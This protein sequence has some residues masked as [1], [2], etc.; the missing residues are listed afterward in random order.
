M[1]LFRRHSERSR[2][3][4]ER[5]GEEPLYFTR[6]RNLFALDH[7]A[8]IPSGTARRRSRATPPFAFALLCLIGGSLAAPAQSRATA[9]AATQPTKPFMF[10]VVSIRQHN[11]A[12]N[13]FER[14]Y[15]PDGFQ[16]T[17][18]IQ[19]LISLAYTPN[20][21]FL[22]SLSKV[23]GAPSWAV[24]NLY[25]VQARVRQ[26]ELPAW[27]ETHDLYH[28]DLFRRG[29]QAALQDRAGLTVHTTT[30]EQPCLNLVVGKHGSRLEPAAPGVV[31]PIP[32]KSY[33]LGAG[34]Y[35]EDNG[36][37]QF[38]GVSMEELALLLT[39]LNKGHLVRDKTGLTGRYD[40]TLPVDNS[41]DDSGSTIPLDRMPVAS[42]GL[43]LK[44]GTA[45]F[46]NIYIDHI[47]RP[48][49]N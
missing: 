39:R 37:R 11:P 2:E 1:H 14:Q 41:P 49:A 43:A 9:S 8:V 34:F 36:R 31:K 26:D 33:K 47:E 45:P 35:I 7:A 3:Q 29:L 24:A 27:Q 40:F 22:G 10:E 46:L 21:S 28:S 20:F 5:H 17:T 23:I 19:T 38:V 48:D 6:T 18:D 42:A 25:D 12:M 32:G 13:G 15:L 16:L 4:C 44:P 30:V